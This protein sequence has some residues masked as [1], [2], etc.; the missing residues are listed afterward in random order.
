[1]LQHFWEIDSMYSNEE[2]FFRVTEEDARG[3]FETKEGGARLTSKERAG[4]YDFDL[5]FAT[6]VHSKESKKQNQLA[7]YQLDLANPLITTNMRALWV[8]TNE[9]H[10]AMGDDNFKDLLPEPPDLMPKSPQQEW[11]LVLQ[12][13]EITIHQQDVHQQ[14][15]PDHLRRIAR[16]MQAP[17]Q[18]QD[19]VAIREMLKHVQEHQTAL[20]QQIDYAGAP[21]LARSAD[22]KRGWRSPRDGRPASAITRSAG[23]A[24][25]AGARGWFAGQWRIR[26]RFDDGRY[27]GL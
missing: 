18:D 17:P 6:S 22:R 1:M 3:Y 26:P 27:R 13:E 24:A 12:G 14:H 23:L 2:V 16:M 9:V 4:K 10:K 11:A 7:L 15:I 20:L 5:R 8:I 25:H 21:G 19:P